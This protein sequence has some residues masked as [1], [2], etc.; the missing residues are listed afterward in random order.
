MARIDTSWSPQGLAWCCW[1]RC[2]DCV[3]A[4]AGVAVGVAGVAAGAGDDV[5][6][7]EWR[8]W[9]KRI[10]PG[11]QPGASPLH[12]NCSPQHPNS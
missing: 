8:R 6:E 5:G 3:A 2:G 7:Q 9:K 11:I 12:Q 1:R 10:L 4:V